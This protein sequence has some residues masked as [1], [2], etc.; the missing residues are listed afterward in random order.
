MDIRIR[1]ARFD[2]AAVIAALAGQL[3]YEAAPEAMEQRLAILRELP[4]HCVLVAQHEGRIAGWIHGFYAVRVESAPFVEIAGLVVDADCRGL[5]IG[6]ALIREV[7]AWAADKAASRMVV[8]CNVKRTASHQF[9]LNA[10]FT[11]IKEQKVFHA[12]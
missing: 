2:D 12:G 3:G 7:A 1:K 4:D 6:R 8:R 11:E 10:G 5:G 9:Y